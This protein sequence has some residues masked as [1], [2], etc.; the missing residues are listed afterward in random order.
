[1]H[2]FITLPRPFATSSP[3]YPQQNTETSMLAATSA[4]AA[5]Q[6]SAVGGCLLVLLL[7]EL[8]KKKTRCI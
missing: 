2:I 7:A 1:V 8:L 5:V 6:G 4:I 3:R